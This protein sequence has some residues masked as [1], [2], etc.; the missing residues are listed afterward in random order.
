[1]PSVRKQRLIQGQGGSS[2]IEL[3]IA[4]PIAM[5]A[6]LVTL[7]MFGSAGR[8][9]QRVEDRAKA[10]TEAHIAAERMTR[11]LRQADWVYFRSSQLV[12]F[13]ARVRS[14]DGSATQLK[15][16]R[17]DCRGETCRRSVGAPVAYPP[18]V[19]PVVR[20]TAV[21]A[22]G[23]VNQDVFHPQ[24]I[25]PNTGLSSVDFLNPESVLVRMKIAPRHDHERYGGWSFENPVEIWDGV[26]LRNNTRFSG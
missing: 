15:L 21:L 10:V 17:Y 24:R 8:G 25:D 9:Y 26:S 23:L 5:V 2:L 12:D 1:M 4:M 19:A 6:L 7:N 11:E 16:V 3:V 18:P 20:Q 13:Q 22:D 14:A